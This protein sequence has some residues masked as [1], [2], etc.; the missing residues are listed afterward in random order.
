MNKLF[1]YT[2]FIF[3]GLILFTET[4]SATT[5]AH[6]RKIR[7]EF[8]LSPDNKLTVNY[9]KELEINSLMALNNLYGETFIVYNPD[10][11]KLKINSAFTRLANGDTLHIPQNALNEVLPSFA[12][13]APAY[14]HLKEMVVTHTG[15]EPGACIHLNYTLLSEGIR[16][17]DIDEILQE[18]TP[19]QEYRIIINVPHNQEFQYKLLNLKGKPE[20]TETT[21]GKRYAWTFRNLQP[22]TNE[23]FRIKNKTDIPHF[24]AS[25]YTSRKSSLE[26]LRANL[27]FGKHEEITRFTKELTQNCENNLDR[28]FAIKD[29]IARQISTLDIPSEY[30]NRKIRTPEEVFNQAYGTQTE[31]INLFI[32]MLQSVGIPASVAV[33]YPGSEGEETIGGLQP[34]QQLLVYTLSEGIPLFFTAD[35]YD[36][37]SPELRGK[38]DQIY[39]LSASEIKPL[40]VL[41]SSGNINCRLNL[42]ISPTEGKLSGNISLAGGLIPIRP[43]KLY[44]EKIK[45]AIAIP[46][47]SINIRYNKVTPFE[48]NL[49][50]ESRFTPVI[51]QDYLL[52]SLPEVATGVHSW[53]IHPLTAN[54][55]E[56]LEI[57]YPI[58]ESY[59]YTIRLAPGLTLKNKCREI[60]KKHRCGAVSVKITQQDDRIHVHREIALPAVV[61][62]PKE[63]K[64]FR[65]ILDTWQD[66][67]A[68]TLIIKHI[69]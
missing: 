27:H 23:S 38:R 4:V 31:K 69:K 59:D 45:E 42:N 25:T 22:R 21:H 35:G 32:T 41:P 11:Q 36:I 9:Y 58:R 3:I 55:K 24:I 8:T 64:H 40:T 1:L 5:E 65:E 68:N 57:P 37:L 56:K 33:V 48:N 19:V 16:H 12:A 63:Y 46:G 49:S 66:K 29:Y 51:N 61:I 20:I 26:A 47:D 14:N 2:G 17:L 62:T 53:K 52:Y 13:N 10:F 60:R 67:I 6:F 18:E 15:L 7:K 54:R 39:L 50:V 34:I 28:T 43:N 44:Q 30:L